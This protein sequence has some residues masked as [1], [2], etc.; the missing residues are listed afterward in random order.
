M[1][2]VFILLL[3]PFLAIAL[4]EL[5][6]PPQLDQPRVTI[7]SPVVM[8]V[9]N[10]NPEISRVATEKGTPDPCAKKINEQ[11]RQIAEELKKIKEQLRS[12]T[13]QRRINNPTSH[14]P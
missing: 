13:D 3:T 4:I 6:H 10:P 14:L 7:E 12:K 8:T 11:Q 1:Q 5:A 9:D 2:N